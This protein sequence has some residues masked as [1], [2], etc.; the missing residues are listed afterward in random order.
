M[1]AELAE[2]VSSQLT[3]LYAEW[4][5]A[6]RRAAKELEGVLVGETPSGPGLK[7]LEQAESYAASIARRYWALSNSI[8]R[9]RLVSVQERELVSH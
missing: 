3:A 6:V 4:V 5:A 8:A 1:S 2:D 7:R 9:G